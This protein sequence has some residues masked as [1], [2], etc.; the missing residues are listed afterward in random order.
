MVAYCD[1]R[2]LY[3]TF[4]SAIASRKKWA[5]CCRT[6]LKYHLRPEEYAR[7][8]KRF[9]DLL[10]HATQPNTVYSTMVSLDVEQNPYLLV[11]AVVYTPG[12]SA[13]TS[14]M[15]ITYGSDRDTPAGHA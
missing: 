13:S 7:G 5:R 6:R 8:G 10:N 9:K 4:K 1:L 2:K 12:R 14:P 15:H 11:F 3:Q